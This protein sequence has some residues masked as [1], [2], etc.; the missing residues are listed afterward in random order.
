MLGGH[1]HVE[2]HAS[3]SGGVAVHH[4]VTVGGYSFI[5]GQSRIVH[6]V[7]RYMLVDGNPRGSA[8][9]TSSA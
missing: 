7:P 2:S 3:I 5:G 9:S 8:A 4:Y 6:D 1:V